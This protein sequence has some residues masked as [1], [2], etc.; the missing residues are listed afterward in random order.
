MTPLVRGGSLNAPYDSLNRA[1]TRKVKLVKSSWKHETEQSLV[2]VCSGDNS[3]CGRLERDVTTFHVARMWSTDIDEGAHAKSKDAQVSSI[4]SNSSASY[5]FRL[6]QHCDAPASTMECP[7]AQKLID[8]RPRFA[9]LKLA[10]GL[11]Y[12]STIFSRKD[13]RPLAL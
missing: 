4:Y 8:S 2:S 3:V 10:L 5:N 12:Q 1:Y 9:P 13:R 6:L 11:S 7:E